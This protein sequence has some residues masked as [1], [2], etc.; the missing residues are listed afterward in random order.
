MIFDRHSTKATV[1]PSTSDSRRR[2]Q[3]KGSRGGAIQTYGVTTVSDTKFENCTATLEGGAVY[4]GSGTASFLTSTFEGNRAFEGAA[5][6]VEAGG[7]TVQDSV[8][9]NNVATATDGNPDIFARSGVRL[10]VCG[11]T[12]ESDVLGDECSAAFDTRS[13]VWTMASAAI[14]LLVASCI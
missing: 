5:I 8:F 9:S 11:N 1:P 12:G 2:L 14:S 7:L 6:F 13:I 3:Q 4:V 10:D